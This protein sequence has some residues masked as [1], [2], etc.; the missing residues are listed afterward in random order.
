MSESTP[1]V[2]EAVVAEIE[3]KKQEHRRVNVRVPI[4]I[5]TVD[6]ERDHR[7]G[8]L[9]FFTSDE[10]SANISRGGAFVATPEDLEPGRRVLVEID[11]PNGSNIQTLGRVVW[12]RLG[13]GRVDVSPATRPGVGIEFTGDRSDQL[14]ELDRYI[15]GASRRR[16]PTP[17]VT[18]GPGKH[19][20][21]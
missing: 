2:R 6:P 1:E 12:K 15:T 4:R 18:G 13:N 7:T 10:V 19:S 21:T 17:A 9:Y 8:K 11:I 3:Q 14:S 16:L 5:S 20:T